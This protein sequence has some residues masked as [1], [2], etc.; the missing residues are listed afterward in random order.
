MEAIK[1]SKIILKPPEI[2][3]FNCSPSSS[4]LRKKWYL[5]SKCNCIF[6]NFDKLRIIL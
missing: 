5:C 1:G 4:P 2:L 3:C 6:N